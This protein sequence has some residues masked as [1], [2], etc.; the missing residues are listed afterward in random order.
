METYGNLNLTSINSGTKVLGV[1]TVDGTADRESGTKD[2][3]D[4]T[5]EFTSQRLETHGTGNLNDILEGNVTRVLDYPKSLEITIP[6][7]NFNINLLFFSFLRSRR[8]S[9][10]ALMTKEEAE[11]TTET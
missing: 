3:L 6:N 5:R 1:L 11:G 10:R 2:F 8:G 7:F 9:L 4:S